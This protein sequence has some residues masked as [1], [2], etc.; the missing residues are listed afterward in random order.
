MFHQLVFYSEIRIAASRF[1]HCFLDM[2]DAGVARPSCK[3]VLEFL[4]RLCRTF[5]EGLDAA[6]GEIANVTSHLVCRRRT[7]G[8]EPKTDAL[9]LSA[10]HEFPGHDH[11]SLWCLVS[12]L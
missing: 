9:H 7:L 11:K 4:D 2:L 8:K 1:E 12:R 6:V 3:I 10:D 5:R